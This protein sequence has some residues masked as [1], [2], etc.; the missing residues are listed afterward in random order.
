MKTAAPTLLVVEDDPNLA[1]MMETYF[2]LQSYRV[3]T[4]GLGNKAVAM[5][6]ADPPDL[7]ILD[8]RLPDIDGFEVCKRLNE[9]HRTRQIPILF[10][11]ER[12]D[13]VDK[14]KGLSLGVI[15]YIT[16]P[17]DIQEVKLRVRNT[18][19]RAEEMRQENP[20]TGLPE[21][22]IVA[23]QFEQRLKESDPWCVVAVG[24]EGI[25]DFRELYGF[26]ASDD[27]LRVTATALHHAA[28]EF[29]GG[30]S[31]GGHL[32]DQ[33]FAFLIP[34]ARLDAFT[35]AIRRRLADHLEYFYPGD[36]RG[37]QAHSSDRLGLA[38]GVVGPQD[39]PF[40]DGRELIAY[41]LETLQPFPGRHQAA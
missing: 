12:S 25:N 13:R 31:L 38:F 32:S 5:A 39:G 37:D 16:K 40:K 9:S 17:F 27:V 19:Q 15:D 8:I 7:I 21:G 24:L 2:S 4:V 29:N 35:N 36:N 1:E 33:T 14:L 30:W 26:L 34:P 10:L 3:K 28:R 11:T 6:Q 18:L 23:R 41:A 22:E 20:I